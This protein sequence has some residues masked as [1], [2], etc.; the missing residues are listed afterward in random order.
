MIVTQIGYLKL[1]DVLKL[2]RFSIYKTNRK[3][4]I[5]IVNTSQEYLCY[6]NK[7]KMEFTI[8]EGKKIC[9]GE[10]IFDSKSNS[11]VELNIKNQIMAYEEFNAYNYYG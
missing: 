11:L 5:L 2:E 4:H 7:S 3:T 10:K 6:P 9:H 8:T 1:E